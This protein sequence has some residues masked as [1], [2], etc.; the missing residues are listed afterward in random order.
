MALIGW[1]QDDTQRAEV[2]MERV[3]EFARRLEAAGVLMGVGTDGPGGGP[4]FATEMEIMLDAGLER[5]RVLELA[6]AGGARVM[7]L[8]HQTGRWAEGYEADI[9]FLRANPLEEMSHARDV[10]WVMS[11]GRLHHVEALIRDVD[12]LGPSARKE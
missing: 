6:T 10:G 12:G 11:N 5:W 7:G 3:F 2:A 9:I 8:G 1:T 4:F